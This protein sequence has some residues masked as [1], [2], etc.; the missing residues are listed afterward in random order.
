MDSTKKLKEHDNKERLQKSGMSTSSVNTGPRTWPPLLR[1]INLFVSQD[2]HRYIFS[3]MINNNP[4][5]YAQRTQI[6]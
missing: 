4:Q 2:G 1:A 6:S 5:A 3:H